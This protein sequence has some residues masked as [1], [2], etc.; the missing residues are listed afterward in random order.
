MLPKRRE[1]KK[2]PVSKTQ[3]ARGTARAQRSQPDPRRNFRTR[4]TER[5]TTCSAGLSLCKQCLGPPR[6]ASPI[7]V[8]PLRQLLPS[9]EA[10]PARGARR[11]VPRSAVPRGAEL[12]RAELLGD[13]QS[14]AVPSRA[15]QRL[16]EPCSVVPSRAW[17]C[18][19][20]PRRAGAAPTP[21][22]GG[23]AGRRYARAGAAGRSPTFPVPS[24][25]E[26][27]L[28]ARSAPPSRPALPAAK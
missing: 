11:A 5:S 9:P 2:N 18:R 4:S 16:A 3:P 23:A 13:T 24:A 20:V 12:R 26:R 17:Q 15:W 28:D 19:A 25:G 14:Q 7:P 8:P 10:V 27:G 22:A 6:P 21:A 1:G